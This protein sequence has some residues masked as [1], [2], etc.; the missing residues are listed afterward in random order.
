MLLAKTNKMIALHLASACSAI[1]LKFHIEHMV[2][3]KKKKMKI[4]DHYSKKNYLKDVVD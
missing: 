4:Y 1:V 3:G 2:P